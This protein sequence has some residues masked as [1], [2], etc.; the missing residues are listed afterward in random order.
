MLQQ[1]KVCRRK[2]AVSMYC[3]F[4]SNLWCSLAWEEPALQL[5]LSCTP[6]LFLFKCCV[7]ALLCDIGFLSVLD[8]MQFSSCASIHTDSPTH[9]HFHTFPVVLGR[10]PYA[11]FSVCSHI[12]I[13]LCYCIILE[14]LSRESGIKKISN[15]KAIIAYCYF[16]CCNL[17]GTNFIQFFRICLVLSNVSN[18][19]ALN[20]RFLQE[21][22]VESRQSPSILSGLSWQG[23]EKEAE[24]HYHCNFWS[25]R[26]RNP[27]KKINRSNSENS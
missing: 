6:F 18:D 13:L 15:W 8:P 16:P 27:P 11:R 2:L 22:Q 14:M 1:T 25:V 9:S 4:S 10:L 21:L 20:Y 23:W 17:C 7:P 24:S 12:I 5:P 26:N 3:L 19:E